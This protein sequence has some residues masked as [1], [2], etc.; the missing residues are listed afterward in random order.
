MG[1]RYDGLLNARVDCG[2]SRNGELQLSAARAAGP[3]AGRTPSAAR[4]PGE[5]SAEDVRELVGARPGGRAGLH[6]RRGPGLLHGRPL[7]AAADVPALAQGRLRPARSSLRRA[8]GTSASRRCAPAS[9]ADQRRLPHLQPAA[10]VREL[11]GRGRA[12]ARATSRRRS[13]TSARSPTCG[14]TPCSVTS[15]GHRA[16]ATCCLGTGP[17]RAAALARWRPRP[18]CGGC[19]HAAPQP[20]PPAR[21]ADP[22]GVAKP[23]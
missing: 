3:G 14:R 20:A 7:R 8:C 18:G 11:P 12:G 15:R 5:D 19:G 16:D 21:A 23:A 22:R 4:A 2:A 13:R 9:L 17:G 10:A 1:F 6:L